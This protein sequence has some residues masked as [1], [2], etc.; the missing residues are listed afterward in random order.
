[1]VAAIDRAMVIDGAAM[2]NAQLLDPDSGGLR[3]VAHSG[4][5]ASLLDLPSSPAHLRLR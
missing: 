1:M 3:I 4:F 2:A 5:K